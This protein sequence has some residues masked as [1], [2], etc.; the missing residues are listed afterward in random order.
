MFLTGLIAVA[1]ASSG[2]A[3]DRGPLT[4]LGVAKSTSL[5]VRPTFPAGPDEFG[6]CVLEFTG[7][8]R[9][10]LSNVSRFSVPCFGMP[11]VLAVANFANRGQRKEVFVVGQEN[12]DFSYLLDYDGRRV[13]ILYPPSTGEPGGR[14][15]S[16]LAWNRSGAFRIKEAYFVWDAKHPGKRRLIVRSVNPFRN[17]VSSGA[18]AMNT[19]RP[20]LPNAM[21]SH[22]KGASDARTASP[23]RSLYVGDS[24]ALYV[25]P[26]F[27]SIDEPA[28]LFLEFSHVVRGRT[29]DKRRFR[30]GPSVGLPR[31]LDVEDFADRGR[32]QI[33]VSVG[34]QTVS[35]YLLD[36]NGKRIEVL[37]KTPAG[38]GKVYSAPTWNA[39]NEFSIEER[40]S[41][42]RGGHK[43]HDRVSVRW[44]IPVLP[45]GK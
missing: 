4:C 3:G 44:E 30:V 22:E 32:S 41:M 42:P 26:I 39:S 33:F 5:F 43:C 11:K 37:Y 12:L 31:M 7:T 38:L 23:Q 21:G 36:Y 25:K 6:E 28:I 17:E 1:T 45:N 20:L 16:R 34:D 2:F 15:Y 18:Q 27:G 24:E 9:G 10:K 40:R 19:S 35:S 13:T 8:R 14:V 29:I